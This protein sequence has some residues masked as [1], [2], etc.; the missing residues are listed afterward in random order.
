MTKIIPPQLVTF[1]KDI[2]LYTLCVTSTIATSRY[3]AMPLT[4]LF[5]EYVLFLSTM[6]TGWLFLTI[7]AIVWHTRG[8]G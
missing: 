3:A 1:T 8:R 2:A 4:R 5:P 7:I 6:I